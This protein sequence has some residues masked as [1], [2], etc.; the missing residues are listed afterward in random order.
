MRETAIIIR[1]TPV[2]IYNWLKLSKALELKG[3]D[4]FIPK[5]T[6]IKNRAYYS[7]SEIREVLYNIRKRKRNYYKKLRDKLNMA[8]GQEVL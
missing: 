8:S 2:T 1:K 6:Y 4:G 7:D 5:P 3:E